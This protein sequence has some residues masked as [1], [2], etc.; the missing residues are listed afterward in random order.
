MA[1]T[2]VDT[3]LRGF[4][5][6]IEIFI[7]PTWQL[8]IRDLYT[9]SGKTKPVLRKKMTHLWECLPSEHQAWLHTNEILHLSGAHQRNRSIMQLI[10]S[11]MRQKREVGNTA[12]AVNMYTLKIWEVCARVSIFRYTDCKSVVGLVAVQLDFQRCITLHSAR[13]FCFFCLFFFC[14][15]L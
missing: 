6:T 11:Q 2:S 10:S 8:D 5:C 1:K 13:F 14:L 12:A 7:I 4:L 15:A 9:H 3:V